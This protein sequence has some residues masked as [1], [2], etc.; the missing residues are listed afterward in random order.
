[1]QFNG[2]LYNIV[3]EQNITYSNL[4]TGISITEGV[5]NSYFRSNISINDAKG[6]QIFSYNGNEGVAVC[7]PGGNSPCNC[8]SPNY[9]AICAFDTTGNL[10]ENFTAYLTG[11][12]ATGGGQ[13]SG[14]TNNA[15]APAIAIGRQ[16]G[17]NCSTTTCLNS[18]LGGNTFRNLVLQTNNTNGNGTTIDYPPIQFQDSTGVTY[19]ATTTF[20]SIVAKNLT[21]KGVVGFGPGS[22]GFGFA[23]YTCGALAAAAVSSTNCLV[24]DPQFISAS[25]TYWNS[26]S[27][28]NLNLASSSPAIATGSNVLVPSFDAYGAA[29]SPLSPTMGAISG[30]TT[31]VLFSKCDLNQD[32]VV[33][34]LD[35]QLATDQAIGATTCGTA[36]LEGNGQCT[37]ID[38]N[39]VGAAALG[40]PC[41]VGN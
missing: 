11:L 13:C 3:A 41:V 6:I 8:V 1:M 28:F 30:L 18:N 21:Y 22:S 15:C 39:R 9:A 23:P 35:V 10:I 4:T 2:K 7:G 32:G 40:G 16:G 36:D 5:Q 31:A 17:G 29:F 20:D 19:L 12:D 25:S 38:V 34:V 24:A 27:S 14:G 26:P 37:A 33:N